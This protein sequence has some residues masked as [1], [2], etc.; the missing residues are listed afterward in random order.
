MCL[1]VE[2]ESLVAIATQE[3]SSMRSVLLNFNNKNAYELD[4]NRTSLHSDM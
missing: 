2:A 3:N 1:S 4:S